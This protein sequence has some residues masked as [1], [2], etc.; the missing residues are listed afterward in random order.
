MHL[1]NLKSVLSSQ[2]RSRDPEHA[3][4]RGKFFYLWVGL[5]VVVPL[6]KFK[7][8]SFIHSSNTEG[9]NILKRVTRQR[10]HPFQEEFLPLG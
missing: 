5:A 1:R 10:P 4:F 9:F 2:K 6:D 8:R 3:L 7:E